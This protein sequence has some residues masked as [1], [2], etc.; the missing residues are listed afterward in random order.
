MTPSLEGPGVR[1]ARAERGRLA[2][3]VLRVFEVGT[4][5]PADR[6]RPR[7]HWKA[8]VR[9]CIE[10]FPKIR[11]NGLIPALALT[12]IERVFGP[13]EMR[14]LCGEVKRFAAGFDA[15]VL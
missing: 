2:V 5:L 4:S 12:T 7:A 11:I 13:T 6:R 8:Y 14:A 10:D 3:R 9:R 1:F 15:D